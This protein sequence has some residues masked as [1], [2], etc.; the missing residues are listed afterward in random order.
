M[1]KH[2]FNILLYVF[3]R[4]TQKRLDFIR[5]DT[6][7][8]PFRAMRIGKNNLLFRSYLKHLFELS[9]VQQCNQLIVDIDQLF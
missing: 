4:S 7:T 9:D 2:K 5:N 3:V 8:F 6:N 1:V